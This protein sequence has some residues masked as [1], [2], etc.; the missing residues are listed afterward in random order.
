MPMVLLRDKF[1]SSLNKRT[2]ILFETIFEF[3]GTHAQVV[4]NFYQL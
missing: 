1:S 4:S 2:H 3:D